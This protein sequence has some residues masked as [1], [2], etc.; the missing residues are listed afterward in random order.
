MTAVCLVSACSALG[1]RAADISSL[2]GKC[3]AQSFAQPH[4]ALHPGQRVAAM[5]VQFQ[6]FE[7]N[8]LASVFYSLRYGPGFGLSA[9]CY[10][11]I[12]GGLACTACTMDSCEA[13]GESFKLYW[14]G[15]DIVQIVNDTTGM[16]AENPDGGRDYLRAGGGDSLFVLPKAAAGTCGW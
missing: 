2:Y 3:F 14:S 10:V 11:R 15:E 16:L 7:G 1:A 9:D 4:L 5:A 8:L 6:G 13:G 12:E